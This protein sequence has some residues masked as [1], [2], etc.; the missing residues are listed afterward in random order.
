MGPLQTN[1]RSTTKYV[2]SFMSNSTYVDESMD[3]SSRWAVGTEEWALESIFGVRNL[4][5]DKVFYL[6][7]DNFSLECLPDSGTQ[8]HILSVQDW[9]YYVL[10]MRL[11]SHWNSEKWLTGNGYLLLIAVFC[12]WREW[13]NSYVFPGEHSE[14]DLWC[15]SWL[16]ST[17]TE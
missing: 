5:F 15:W 8:N 16:R 11:R 9:Y 7:D 6:D 10:C 4:D 13:F 3:S 12:R 17:C 14:T 2:T 1:L